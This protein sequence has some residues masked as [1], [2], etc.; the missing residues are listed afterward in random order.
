MVTFVSNPTAVQGC[1][2][3]AATK[4][5]AGEVTGVHETSLFQPGNI[6]DIAITVRGRSKQTVRLSYIGNYIREHDG[7]AAADEWIQSHTP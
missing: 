7:W 5:H 6:G 4:E 3:S 1:L 2:A